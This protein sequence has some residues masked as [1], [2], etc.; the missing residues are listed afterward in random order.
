M[1]SSPQNA[2]ILARLQKMFPDATAEKCYFPPTEEEPTPQKPTGLA[3][4]PTGLAGRVLPVQTYVVPVDSR[5]APP[6]RTITFKGVTITT[7]QKLVIE[8]RPLVFIEVFT[9]RP[10]F[11]F[12]F[13]YDDGS[14]RMCNYRASAVADALGQKTTPDGWVVSHKGKSAT[15]GSIITLIDGTRCKVLG[16]LDVKKRFSFKCERVTKD[17]QPTGQSIRVPASMMP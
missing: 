8:G 11:P 13:K 9:H 3:G 2:A 12:R 1:A 16:L 7:G 14:G 15:V 10:S 4:L 5:P 17:D 6:P